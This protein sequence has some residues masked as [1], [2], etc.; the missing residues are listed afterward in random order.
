MK[1]R[2]FSAILAM[3]ILAIIPGGMLAKDDDLAR[4]L[5]ESEYGDSHGQIMEMGKISCYRQMIAGEDT[6]WTVN[7]FYN[8]AG[9]FYVRFWV[10]VMTVEDEGVLP[11]VMAEILNYNSRQCGPKFALDGETYVVKLIFDLPT[12]FLTAE[13]LEWAIDESVSVCE[14]MSPIFFKFKTEENQKME[15]P[16]NTGKPSSKKI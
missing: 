9:K 13:I 10:E 6:T 11:Q 3:V 15:T 12:F 16:F 8:N 4:I 7:F 5:A 2:V 14:E 1:T